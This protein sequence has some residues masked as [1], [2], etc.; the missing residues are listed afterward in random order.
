M[1]H[2]SFLMIRALTLTALALLV[3]SPALAAGGTCSTAAVS[4]FQPKAKLESQLK[5]E[6]LTVRQIK[7]EKGCYEVYALDKA[8]KKVNVA[9][10]AQT[11]EKLA[12]AEAGEN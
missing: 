6:G 8:G 2:R 9:Y 3:A 4:A 10:N 1:Q 12:N 11:L 7:V 5:A